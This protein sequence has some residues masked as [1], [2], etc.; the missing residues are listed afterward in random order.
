MEICN[1][2]TCKIMKRNN[3]ANLILTLFHTCVLEI[4]LICWEIN[5]P[6]QTSSEIW[7]DKM[8]VAKEV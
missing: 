5:I 7:S 3:F 1:T 4:N 6:I 8:I 2:V